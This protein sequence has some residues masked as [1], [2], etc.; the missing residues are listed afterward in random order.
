MFFGTCILPFRRIDVFVASFFLLRAIGSEPR[1]AFLSFG[2]NTRV[3]FPLFSAFLAPSV[4]GGARGGAA[5]SA[6]RLTRSRLSPRR[7]PP[8]GDEIEPAQTSTLPDLSGPPPRQSSVSVLALL[9]SVDAIA[10]LRGLL[11]L[12]GADG[13]LEHRPQMPELLLTLDRIRRTSRDFS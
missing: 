5:P 2:R 7:V 11:V 4:Q 9:D 6:D 8:E 13:P 12:L 3:R 1:V 10:N